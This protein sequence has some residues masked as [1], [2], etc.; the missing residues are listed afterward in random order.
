M[1][2]NCTNP[3]Y[4]LPL[5]N[6]SCNVAS[7]VMFMTLVNNL[8]RNQ[9]DISDVC[10]RIRPTLN[11][12]NSYDFIVVGGGGAGSV[13]AG[14]L[15]ENPNWKVL[16]IE[17]GNDEPVGSQVPTFA[18]T[19]IGN[20]ETTLFYPTERQANACRQNANN[21]C[22][23]VRAKA[24]GGC[25]V[26][27]GMTYMR[28]VPR[29]YDYWAELGNTG[30]SYD[31]LLPYFIK[32]EDNGNIGN[33]TSTEY[34][35]VGG[36]LRVE[37]F[38]YAPPIAQDILAAARS[39]GYATPGDL[40]A[41]VLEGFVLTQHMNKNGTRDSTARAYLR[42]ARARPNLHIMLNSTATK[43]NFSQRNGLAVAR[44]VEFS[45]NGRRYNVSVT[46]EVIVSGGTIGSPQLLLLSGIGPRADLEDVNVTVVRDLPGVG[47]NFQNHVSLFVRFNLTKVPDTNLLTRDA[48]NQY[49][50]QHRGPLS[51][52]GLAQVGA[53]FSSSVN[54]E[55]NWPD[56]QIYFAGYSATCAYGNGSANLPADPNQPNNTRL[57]TL[58]VTLVRAKSRGYIKLSSNNPSGRLIVQPNY[59]QEDYD[60]QAIVSGIKT[61]IRVGNADILK[62]KYGSELVRNPH[63]NCSSLY[64][65]GS[66]AF[67]ECATRYSTYQENH[68][69]GT[70]KM[71]PQSDRMAVVDPELKVHGTS[72][73]R[74]ADAS[75]YPEN[76]AGN[77]FATVVLVGERAADF[78]KSDW[79]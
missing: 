41:D 72:N 67:W 27:N 6:V 68:L 1:T 16:L 64:Q 71:G 9:C 56:I 35:G 78:I 11:P 29:D 55:Q 23:Y 43:I 74:V 40:N 48:V 76:I 22:T 77:T 13:V 18:F 53:R 65:F 44:S 12:D 54:Q 75:I 24:L 5:Q 31:D 14:R 51:S 30:W 49:L 17:Q 10:G 32:S 20:S 19:F 42:S 2:C 38:P 79:S 3:F 73:V 46:K 57:I 69:T 45:Y 50:S 47:Q 26:V 15:S 58:Q 62:Q 60:V 66:D 25:G 59:L 7:S 4:G 21:Q 28:G 61:A 8:L 36:P 34:H 70:C 37:R 33:L 63:G 52:T 39:A